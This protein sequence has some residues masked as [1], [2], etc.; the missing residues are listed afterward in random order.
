MRTRL[1]LL[2]TAV[3]MSTAAHAGPAAKARWSIEIRDTT[4]DRSDATDAGRRIG[5]VETAIGAE[6]MIVNVKEDDASTSVFSVSMSGSESSPVL[7]VSERGERIGE[8]DVHLPFPSSGSPVTAGGYG[9]GTAAD[10]DAT[11]RILVARR[12]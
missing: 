9:Q 2:M 7:Q 8:I 11:Y 6:P 1:A 4:A 3:V 12:K 5:L 10:G